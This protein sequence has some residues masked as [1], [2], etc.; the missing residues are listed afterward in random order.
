MA[1]S[2]PLICHLVHPLYKQVWAGLSEEARSQLLRIELDTLRETARS[3]VESAEQCG[4]AGMSLLQE[5]SAQ[6]ICLQASSAGHRACCMLLVCAPTCTYSC[7]SG[8]C[9]LHMLHACKHLKDAVR[10]TCLQNVYRCIAHVVCMPCAGAEG[11][12]WGPDPYL[13]EQLHIE[14]TLEEALAR[15]KE[16]GTWKVWVDWESGQEFYDAESFRQHVVVSG[17][18]VSL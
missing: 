1:T 18:R 4:C 17:R 8:T 11:C 12:S 15:L 10:R 14:E 3:V 2:L 5:L 7:G 16:R 13:T 9:I 6:C